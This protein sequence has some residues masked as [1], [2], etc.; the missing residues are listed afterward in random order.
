MV[1]KERRKG[2][3]TYEDNEITRGKLLKDRHRTCYT[4]KVN[5]KT[6]FSKYKL[7]KTL[8]KHLITN[9]NAVISPV[10]VIEESGKEHVLDV[11]GTKSRTIK[12]NGIKKIRVRV[13]AE[14][15]KPLFERM[16][17]IKGVMIT[18]GQYAKE[19]IWEKEA[20]LELDINEVKK[21]TPDYDY[22]YRE[23]QMMAERQLMRQY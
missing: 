9:L 11:P 8:A 20:N 5:D 4:I 13:V 19:C 18:L 16:D 12:I 10:E 21:Y 22:E 14:D 1:G 3:L 23:K 17:Q 15:V 6:Y 2:Y 7:N